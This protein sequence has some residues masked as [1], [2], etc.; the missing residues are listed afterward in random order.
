MNDGMN[1]YMVEYLNEWTNEWMQDEQVN[2]EAVLL[3]INEMLFDIFWTWTAE[4]LNKWI[5]DWISKVLYAQEV[6][7]RP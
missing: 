3:K 6:V 1:A 4:V 7:T 2:R 5:E